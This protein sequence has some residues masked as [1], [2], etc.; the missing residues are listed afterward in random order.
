M[1]RARQQV[2]QPPSKKAK[3]S[4][5]APV[6]LWQEQIDNVCERENMLGTMT[7]R[8]IDRDDKVAP[9]TV[10]DVASLRAFFINDKRDKA[11]KKALKIVTD[12]Q[13]RGSAMFTTSTGNNVIRAASKEVKSIAKEKRATD[14]VNRLFMLTRFLYEVPHWIHDNE[15]WGPGDGL[16][17]LIKH[18][19][20]VWKK[21]LKKT[22]N[23][24]GVDPEFS[25][26]AIETV[27]EQFEGLVDGC[28]SV[29]CKFDY[30]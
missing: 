17:Q 14:Q 26:P 4:E 7:I 19:A 25:K 20:G 5:K 13:E 24:L 16:E 6:D 29:S 15:M 11:F 22:D 18:I 10:E 1:Q 27:L 21:L 30:R 28:E 23:E 3:R 8:G 12:G 2:D 9:Y